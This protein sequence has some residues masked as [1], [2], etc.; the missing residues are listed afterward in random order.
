[1]VNDVSSLIAICKRNTLDV[2]LL[3]HQILYYVLNF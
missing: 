1:M 2:S 3:S